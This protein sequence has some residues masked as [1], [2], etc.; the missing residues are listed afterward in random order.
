[1]NAEAENVATGEDYE[2]KGYNIR[3][4]VWMWVWHEVWQ[5]QILLSELHFDCWWSEHNIFDLCQFFIIGEIQNNICQMMMTLSF[6]CESG[7]SLQSWT[8]CWTSHF[9]RAQYLKF[10]L[11]FNL[12]VLRCWTLMLDYKFN[13]T[14]V[15]SL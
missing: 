13:W 15:T 4:E 8:V 12:P 1:M 3:T 9:C 14:F 6:I 7:E 5:Q 2:C 11:L 10:L